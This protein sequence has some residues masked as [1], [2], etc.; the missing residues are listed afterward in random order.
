[1]TPAVGQRWRHRTTNPAHQDFGRVVSV[2]AVGVTHV[3]IKGK[4]ESHWPLDRFLRAYTY[5]DTPV[6]EP[7]PF[8]Q[9]E[10]DLETVRVP[11]YGKG[12]T[13]QQRF[14]LFH[15]ENPWVLRAYEQLCMDWVGKGN[16]R[17][18]IG[19]FTEIVRW[20]YGR[21]TTGRDFKIDNSYRSRY[22]RLI[23]ERNPGWGGLFE[24]REL[25][26]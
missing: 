5:L 1:V 16:T 18:S 9:L 4:H 2:V 3:T 23:V 15:A 10:L 12:A 6:P 19:M 22:V 24:T 20:Q 13:L 7:E 21:R 14:E 11:D 25:R 8:E 17:A 26:A